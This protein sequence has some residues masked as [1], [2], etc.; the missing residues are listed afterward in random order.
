MAVSQGNFLCFHLERMQN[1]WI[2]QIR[3]QQH[4]SVTAQVV[5]VLGFVALTVF[6]TLLS[7]AV[8]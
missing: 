2:A 5:N 7:P 8:V 6:V 1:V 3:G 4:F